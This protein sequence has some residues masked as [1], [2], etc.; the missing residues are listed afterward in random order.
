MEDDSTARRWRERITLLAAMF[1]LAV[2]VT[3]VVRPDSDAATWAVIGVGTVALISLLL[4]E[5][6]TFGGSRP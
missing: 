5:R 3:A 2:A 6:R 4:W 1:P